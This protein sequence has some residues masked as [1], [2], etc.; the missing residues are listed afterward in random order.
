MVTTDRR[1]ATGARKASS[2]DTPPTP[3]RWHRRLRM[4]VYDAV[5]GTVA[6]LLV[7]FVLYPLVLTFFRTFRPDG[8]WDFSAVGAVISAPWFA[9]ALWDTVSAVSAA[10]LL[11][12]VVA[13]T[14][15]WL[16]ERTNANFG[17][18]GEILPLLPLLVPPIAMT[19]GWS[20][21][22][23]P[24]IGFVN[25]AL[26]AGG[27]GSVNIQSWIGLV[28]VYALY[29]VPFI[30]II[31][32]AALRNL[33]PALEEASRTSGAGLGRT[34]RKVTL[35]AVRPALLSALVLVVIIGL[36]QYSIPRII[37]PNAG[38]DILSVRII[39]M[40]AV[41]YPPRTGEAVVV[42]GLL[43]I[44]ILSAW[45]FQRRA[46]RAGTHATISGRGRRTD[47]WQLPTPMKWLA[48]GIMLGYILCASLLPVTAI[49]IVS[50]QP[51]WRPKIDVSTFTLSHF[52]AVFDD[53]VALTAIK[54][55]LF[56]GA[57]AGLLGVVV[58]TVVTLYVQQ[59]R[60]AWTTFVDTTSKVPAALSNVVIG[61]GFLFAFSG[62][63]FNWSGTLLIL[64]MCYL[65]IHMP[66]ASLAADAAA[67][68]VGRELSEASYVSGAGQGRTLGKVMVPLMLP[69]L[70][71]A[72]ALLFVMI[73]GELAASSLLA[74]VGQPVIGF[75]LV[76]IWENGDYGLM[77][78]FA[79]I[80]TFLAAIVVSTTFAISRRM[81]RHTR[82]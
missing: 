1:E 46:T 58:A 23:L 69:G 29:F 54:N 42:S 43:F 49:L 13:T 38:L 77:A 12:A 11:A 15:A 32:A 71:G 9:T 74:G 40:L 2:D 21:L 73:A 18:I 79:A 51:F 53:H 31:V 75:V 14:I 76:G 35:P 67:A 24:R 82:Q 44:V 57:T 36:S 80:V 30:Y 25:V 3:S 10:G 48:R 50:L 65:V 64:F 41:E 78:A 20:L 28:W 8:Q 63:P 66:Q 5:V 68:Q 60:A 61:V 70:I 27:L 56:F 17:L 33:D 4:S 45:L 16:N 6:V 55:S 26:V 7:F 19:I 52:Q 22:G 59:R 39:R 62:A 37:A 47:R 81:Q 72:W 34:L